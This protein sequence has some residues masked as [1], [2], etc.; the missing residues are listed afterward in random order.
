V[1][2]AAE[3]IDAALQV[4]LAQEDAFVLLATQPGIGH[5]REDLTEPSSQVLERL[6]LPGRVRP[7][8]VSH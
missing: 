7:L 2:N 6:L 8:P 5:A 1:R 3:S 4:T